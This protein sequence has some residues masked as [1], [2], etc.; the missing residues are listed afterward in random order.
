MGL[1]RFADVQVLVRIVERTVMGDCHI[2]VRENG[3]NYIYLL[4]PPMV[5]SPT[6]HDSLSR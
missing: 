1:C 5:W 2:Q 4:W 6:G 3:A